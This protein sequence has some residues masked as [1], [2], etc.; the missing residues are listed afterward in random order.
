MLGYNCTVF[1]YGQTG[2]G[3]THTMECVTAPPQPGKRLIWVTGAV[4]RGVVMDP[5]ERGIIPRSIFYIFEELDKIKADF[6]VRVS[7]LELY[8]EELADLLAD[9]SDRESSP[10]LLAWQRVDAMT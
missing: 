5:D 3:K 2:T 8:N 9:P 4:H 7:F 1:T 6:T 10:R